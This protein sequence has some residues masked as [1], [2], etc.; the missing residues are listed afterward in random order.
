MIN[1][2]FFIAFICGSFALVKEYR[3]LVEHYRDE[4]F[5]YEYKENYSKEELA[6]KLANSDRFDF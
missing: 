3:N 2:I 6:D 5:F 4:R 1:L